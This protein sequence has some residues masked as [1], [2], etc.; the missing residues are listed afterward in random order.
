M[1][2][3]EGVGSAGGQQRCR[4]DRLAER[5]SRRQRAGVMLEQG[6]GRRLLRRQFPEECC[7]DRTAPETLVS[8]V[9]PDPELFEQVVHCRQAA[10]RK[11]DVVRMELGAGDGAGRAEGRAPHRLRAAEA[12]GATPI[13]R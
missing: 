10:A 11:R 4:D 1:N 3:D 5:G 8:Q 9:E 7:L 12:E 6:I 2:Q 13:M